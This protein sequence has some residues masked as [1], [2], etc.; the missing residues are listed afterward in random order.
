MASEGF[1]PPKSMTADLQLSDSSA[2]YGSCGTVP[3]FF[4]SQTTICRY[5]RFRPFPSI[6]RN[7]SGTTSSSTD[8]GLTLERSLRTRGS[9]PR[10]WFP[11]STGVSG[12]GLNFVFNCRAITLESYF[13]SSSEEL[14]GYDNAPIASD[15]LLKI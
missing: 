13:G 15:F 2:K 7:L 10:A 8:C 6:V 4:I 9:M 11:T 1:E 3:Q 14:I 5:A 12:V